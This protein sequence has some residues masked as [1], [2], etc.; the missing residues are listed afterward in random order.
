M[1]VD[2]LIDPGSSLGELVAE[3]PARTQLF[4]H[5]RLDY[6]CGG[7]QTLAAACGKRGLELEEVLAALQALDERG[8]EGAGVESRDWREVETAELCAHI[9][10]VHHDG[11]REVFPRIKRLLATVVRVHGDSEPRLRDAQRCFSEIR[12]ELEPHLASEENVLFPACIASDQTGSPVE[13]L[14]LEEHESEHA[15]LGRALAALRILCGDYDRQ[16]ALCN[17]HRALLDALEAF[18][19]D[20]HRHVHEENNI[21]L[22][23]ARQARPTPK[24]EARSPAPI[25]RPTPA[26]PSEAL[27]PCCEGW[28]AEQTH[29][30]AA[31]QRG[32]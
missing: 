22:V 31:Q 9:V 21:L 18:E 24:A 5:L 13:E 32:R 12:S 20:L 4:E 15:A 19:Q 25:D 1:S 2:S 26:S 23:R 3:R 8:L 6:C 27:P 16:A 28:I 11:L 30:W 10:T 7:R 14:M 17:T 29:S